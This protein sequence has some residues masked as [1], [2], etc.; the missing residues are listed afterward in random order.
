MSIRTKIIT[1]IL[2]LSL[3]AVMVPT[4]VVQG[5]LTESQIQS[6]LSLLTSFG[7]DATTVANVDASLRGTTPTTPTT[8]TTI[9]GIPA[10]FTFTQTHQYGSVDS[11]VVYLKIVLAAEGCVSGL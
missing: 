6:I 3:V 9:T 10:G 1:A 8:P 11:D 2:S 4:G 7:A 5:A